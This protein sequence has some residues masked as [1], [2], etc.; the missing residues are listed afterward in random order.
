M[1]YNSVSEGAMSFPANLKSLEEI[2]SG[3]VDLFVF[4]SLISR[5][6]LCCVRL[7]SEIVGISL[8]QSPD[9]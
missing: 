7:T 3:P 4:S 8:T 1:W 9:R 6:T 2:L 5:L